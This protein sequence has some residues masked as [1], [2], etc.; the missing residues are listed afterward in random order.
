MRG[1]RLLGMLWNGDELTFV[2]DSGNVE[3]CS[4]C[5]QIIIAEQLSSHH[6]LIPTTGAET[7]LLD[8]LDEDF[9]DE[10]NDQVR[11]GKGLDGTLY[12]FVLC[13]HNPPHT[14]QSRGPLTPRGQKPPRDNAIVYW[15]W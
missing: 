2:N 15:G 5:H 6:C 14:N 9:T 11:L 12:S 4:R 1:N 13:K 3:R 7:I 8:W 10:N